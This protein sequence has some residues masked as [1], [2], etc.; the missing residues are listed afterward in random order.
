MMFWAPI[1]TQAKGPL[2]KLDLP[3]YK[4]AKGRWWREGLN[5][6]NYI[7]QILEGPL[8]TF[9][10]E[11][12]KSTGLEM[13]VVE[14]SASCHRGA[15]TSKRRAELGMKQ[16]THPPSSPDLNPI[17]P[18]W[19]LWKSCIWDIPGSHSSMAA[20]KKAA[21]EAWDSITL[22]DILKHTSTMDDQVR[23][24]DKAKGWHTRY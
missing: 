8:K 1:T 9:W 3:K 17:E 2:I 15:K 10:E 11:C 21:Y 14:D 5:Q 12:S 13:L 20:L 7:T 4:D 6:T 16:L 23:V 22:E 18:I 24:V 19:F